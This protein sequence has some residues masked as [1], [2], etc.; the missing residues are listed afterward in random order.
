MGN[1][2]SDKLPPKHTIHCKPRGVGDLVVHRQQGLTKR[3]RGERAPTLHTKWANQ[4]HHQT[5]ETPFPSLSGITAV[6]IVCWC[7]QL[8]GAG[9]GF[10]KDSEGTEGPAEGS[11]CFLQCW[12]CW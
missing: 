1:L 7:Y 3:T 8:L 11:S 10:K 4:Q 5:L 6:R 2:K 12:S 9:Y